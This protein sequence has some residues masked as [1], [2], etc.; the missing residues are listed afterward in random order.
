MKRENFILRSDSYGW[1]HPEMYRAIP[2]ET[3]GLFAYLEARPGGEYPQTVWCGLQYILQRYLEGVRVTEQDLNEASVVDS[4]HFAKPQ[5]HILGWRHI[6]EHHG[7][8]LPLSIKAAPEGSVIPVG[9]ALMTVESTDPA[10]AWLVGAIEPI[11]EKVWYPMAVA[12]KSW[13]TRCA[14]ER[15]VRETG[16]ERGASNYMLHD[17]GYR[18]V[19]SEESAEIGAGAHLLSG[20]KGTDTIVGMRWLQDWYGAG[21]GFAHSVAASQHS[22]MTLDGRA[23][24]LA[25]AKEIIRTHEGQILSLV[26]DSYD[27]YRFVR[28]M[29]ANK[30]LIDYHK[31]QLV[32]RPDSLTPEHTT[33]EAVVLWTLHQLSSKLPITKTQTGHIRTA[34]K[35]LWGDGLDA[36]AIERVARAAVAEGYAADNLVF[37]M[38]GGL[39]QKVHRDTNRVAYKVSARLTDAE[40]IP[41]AKDPLDPSK[42][43]KA[44]RLT[45]TRVNGHYKTE[46]DTFGKSVMREVF[47]NGLVMQQWTYEQVVQAAMFD[48]NVQAQ[49]VVA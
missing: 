7:G 4:W 30:D 13:H 15:L 26:A 41:M 49:P 31:V 46:S 22:I 21:T 25:I 48:L 45:L 11:L 12:T 3:R 35:V 40:W 18:G 39:L 27:Y 33:P 37:G 38:G 42:R 28:A 14:L 5:L 6:I 10:C 32:L 16:G 2:D 23:G 9:N 17:F 24:E 29:I 36:E 47:R 34:Y 1:S 44:G 19:S 43:S 20:A 8:R